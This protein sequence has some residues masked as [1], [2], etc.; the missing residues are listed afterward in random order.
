MTT[1]FSAFNA[2]YPYPEVTPNG[3]NAAHA[4]ALLHNCAGEAS[5]AT[6][7]MLYMYDGIVLEKNAEIARAFRQITATE[8]KHLELFAALAFALGADPRLWTA[9]QGGLRYWTPRSI[10]YTVAP[11]RALE[12]ALALEYVTI[13]RYERQ[14]REI[15]DEGVQLLLRRVLLDEQL[16]VELFR[17]LLAKL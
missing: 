13:A 5:E 1:E 15:R 2:D 6:S 4:R 11:R 10:P 17:S 7:A 16:H 9:A 14:A 12:N 3:K 8:R